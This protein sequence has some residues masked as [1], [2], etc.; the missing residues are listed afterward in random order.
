MENRG[1]FNWNA[2]HL[3]NSPCA[4]LDAAQKYARAPNLPSYIPALTTAGSWPNAK[5]RRRAVDALATFD[6]ERLEASTG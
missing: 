5:T 6:S 1:H 3:E 2:Y 4:E